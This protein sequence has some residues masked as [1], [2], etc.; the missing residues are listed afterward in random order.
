MAV[1][2]TWLLCLFGVLLVSQQF[3]H[4][5]RAEADDDAGEYEDDEVPEAA[6]EPAVVES[7]DK[8]VH[9]LTKSNFEKVSSLLF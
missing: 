7:S 6:A 2:R 1:S 4:V 9:V 5:V 8:N 3:V